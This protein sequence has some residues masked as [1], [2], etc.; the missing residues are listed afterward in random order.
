MS[1]ILLG[2]RG[3]YHD[4]LATQVN[5]EVSEVVEVDVLS[6]YEVRTAAQHREL[7]EL[8]L[9]W[10]LEPGGGPNAARRVVL[11]AI[12]MPPLPYVAPFT[13]SVPGLIKVIRNFTHESLAYLR[14]LYSAWELLP[15]VLHSR[16]R[17]M[18]KVRPGGC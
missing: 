4:L 12:G 18:G 13:S 15:A 14:G 16:D 5:K 9:P 10:Q 8:G 6:D 2:T 7:E 11:D 3:R 17:V 1:E